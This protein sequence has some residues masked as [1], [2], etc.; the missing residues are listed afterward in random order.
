MKIN[1]F[2]KYQDVERN[3]KL[4]EYLRPVIDVNS[5]LEIML[6]DDRVWIFNPI[7]VGYAKSELSPPIVSRFPRTAF[8]KILFTRKKI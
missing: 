5:I 2:R 1:L 3:K 6:L 7:L 4:E 8:L